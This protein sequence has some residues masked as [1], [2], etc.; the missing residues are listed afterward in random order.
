MID[1]IDNICD[2]KGRPWAKL[3]EVKVGDLLEADNGFNCIESNTP[4]TVC[5]DHEGLYIACAE[6]YHFLKGQAD[7]GEHLIGLYKL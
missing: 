6:G 5:E 7:D 4:H 1:N 2:R 3:S